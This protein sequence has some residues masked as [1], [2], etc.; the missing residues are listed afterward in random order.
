VT[1]VLLVDDEP[2]ICDTASFALEREGY[3][4]TTAG[5]AE[6]ALAAF[7]QGSFDVVLLDIGL[8][9]GSG[10]D[11]CR[12]IR[13][14]GPTPIVI[15]SARG[16]ESDR[17]VGLELG[18]DD[19]VTKP[20]S[21][22]ELVSRVRAILRRRELDRADGS[23]STRRVGKLVLDQERHVA[24]V[25][26]VPRR[27]T[28]SEFRILWMLASRPEHVFSRRDIMRELWQTDRVG[29]ERSCDV[30]VSNLRRKLDPSGS[31]QR[32]VTVRG[33]G[34]KLTAV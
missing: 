28:L 1:T 34:Y 26:G 8:P 10:L 12:A 5:G 11:V 30:H 21:L 15:L 7:N 16:T 33:V 13:A 25:E 14:S 19:Y 2:G 17:V 31:V 24:H 27:L 3:D 4:V 23:S 18:A 6:D 29:D 9:D 32:I 20:F 22:A